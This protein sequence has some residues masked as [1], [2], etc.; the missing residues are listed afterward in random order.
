MTDSLGA[1]V[2][3]IDGQPVLRLLSRARHPTDIPLRQ[4]EL[5]VL[6]RDAVDAVLTRIEHANGTVPTA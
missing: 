6:A 4:G 2:L 5:E 1:R 3:V